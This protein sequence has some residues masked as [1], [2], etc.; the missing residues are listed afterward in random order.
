MAK[1]IPR[2]EWRTFGDDLS[3]GEAN[4]RKH[5]PGKVRESSEIY[6]LSKAGNDNTKIRDEK[7][8]IKTLLRVNREG[9][10]QWTPIMKVDFP[11]HII[12]LAVVYKAFNLK[13]PYFKKD[14]YS[15]REY[16][17]EL[18]KPAEELQIVNVSKKRYGYTINDCI[19]EIAEVKFN[20]YETGTIA[21][22][23]TDPELVLNTVKKLELIDRE[24]INYIKAMKKVMGLKY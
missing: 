10:E 17:E 20:D 11:I 7:M 5:P 19:V 24:N 1:I 18:V 13:Y 16:L 22:E 8:D 12:E 6:I 23:H 3:T 14:E 21:V 2:W 15:Y 9:L 4:I